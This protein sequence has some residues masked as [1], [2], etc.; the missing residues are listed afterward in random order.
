MGKLHEIL[1]VEAALEGTYKIVLDE[2]RKTFGKN[3]QLFD[4][5]LKTLTMFSED[6]AISNGETGRLNRET[7]VA[8]KL[9]YTQE[10][11]VRYYDAI[12][13]KDLANRLAKS[14]IIIDGVT[15]A[16][17]VP[18]TFLLAM[19][20]RLK[21]LRA[22][23]ADMPTLA[24]GVEW[25]AA[26][27]EGENVWKVAHPKE[28]FKTAKTKKFMEVAKATKEHKAQI[29]KWDDVKNV[30]KYT[31]E[32]TSGK[33]TSGRKSK[34]LAKIDKMINAVRVAR[35][36]ANDVTVPNEQI[37]QKLVDYILKD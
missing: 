33:V 8:E 16:V 30:G 5:A 14:D 3:H 12:Y 27:E 7:T 36:K 9:D 1:A 18:A 23:L 20:K 28:S 34:Y 2:T 32:F 24:V 15:I 11:V 29:D 21:G 19:E 10:A 31:E 6:D 22:V 25:V 4:G 26:P 13:Q 35:T 17:D 37:G